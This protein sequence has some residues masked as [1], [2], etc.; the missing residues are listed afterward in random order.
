MVML[1]MRKVQ[2]PSCIGQVQSVLYW[3]QNFCCAK[4]SRP[5]LFFVRK[6]SKCRWH[7]K[8]TNLNSISLCSLR[9]PEGCRIMSKEDVLRQWNKFTDDFDGSAWMKD[10][11]EIPFCGA[12]LRTFG[13]KRE[14][15]PWKALDV[16]CGTGKYTVKLMEAGWVSNHKSGSMFDINFYLQDTSKFWLKRMFK[17]DVRFWCI[18]SILSV[19]IYHAFWLK[20]ESRSFWNLYTCVH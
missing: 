19:L 2:I 15:A 8:R 4:D 3:V 13:E 17:S 7:F 12:Y 1:Q 16:G 11:L 5:T 14:G 10:V 6:E 9:C 18:W 20:L